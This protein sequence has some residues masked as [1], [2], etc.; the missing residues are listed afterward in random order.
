MSTYFLISKLSKS[1]GMFTN[2]WKTLIFRHGLTQVLSR[3][4]PFLIKI[5][6]FLGLNTKKQSLALHKNLFFY[7][8]CLLSYGVKWY[9]VAM[10]NVLQN[11]V[12]AV[13]HQKQALSMP[14]DWLLAYVWCWATALVGSWDW[15]GLDQIKNT[16]ISIIKKK[17]FV[18]VLKT[19][20]CYDMYGIKRLRAQASNVI[21]T[22][23]I[24]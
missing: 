6:V 12:Y 18:F 4:C 15:F 11:S 9:M 23:Y 21:Y 8:S 19:S 14:V 22:I 1:I 10:Q 24:Y 7:H 3:L 5:T 2:L 17:L 13:M 16:I 20:S